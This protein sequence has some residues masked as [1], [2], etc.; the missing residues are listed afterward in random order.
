MFADDIFFFILSYN[1]TTIFLTCNDTVSYIVLWMRKNKLQLKLFN[2][3]LLIY[4]TSSP[5]DYGAH[6]LKRKLCEMFES[7]HHQDFVKGEKGGILEV[8]LHYN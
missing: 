5:T 8:L 1:I 2:N 7:I 6:H 4:Q 3:R